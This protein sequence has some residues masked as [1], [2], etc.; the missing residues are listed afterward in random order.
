[1]RKHQI[2][3]LQIMKKKNTNK[4]QPRSSKK[5]G[6]YFGD[7]SLNKIAMDLNAAF[8]AAS[9]FLKEAKLLFCTAMAAVVWLVQIRANFAQTPAQQ[10]EKIPS[11]KY[12][13]KKLIGGENSPVLKAAAIIAC[14][15]TSVFV[16]ISTTSEFEAF[17]QQALSSYSPNSKHFQNLGPSNYL[18]WIPGFMARHIGLFSSCPSSNIKIFNFPRD[19]NLWDIN[20]FMAALGPI[21]QGVDPN[22]VLQNL[23]ELV[24]ENEAGLA[25]DQL[26]FSEPRITSPLE[27]SVLMVQPGTQINRSGIPEQSKMTPSDQILIE[28]YLTPLEQMRFTQAQQYNLTNILSSLINK[29]KELAASD[30]IDVEGQ[31]VQKP[32]EGTDTE[33]KEA[34]SSLTPTGILPASAGI[35]TKVSSGSEAIMLN[36]KDTSSGK[37][38]AQTPRVRRTRSNSPLPSVTGKDPA[39]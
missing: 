36:P 6:I 18:L 35:F 32:P 7:I 31:T 28:K 34:S 26:Q 22:Q 9:P 30:A 4:Q 21:A 3:D 29:A 14:L 8:G 25:V 17:V 16:S 20:K 37:E 33:N 27:Q 13:K 39:N 1:M 24:F 11:Y 15:Q 12:F 23:Q 5:D 2:E 10:I 38:S 19:V